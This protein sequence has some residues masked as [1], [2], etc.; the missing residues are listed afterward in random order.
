MSSLFRIIFLVLIVGCPFFS[1]GQQYTI[2]QVRHNADSIMRSLVGESIFKRCTY[3]PHTYYNYKGQRKKEAEWS[4]LDT[5]FSTRGKVQNIFVR[6]NVKYSYPHCPEYNTV[7]GVVSL[8]LDNKLQLNVARDLNIIPDYMLKGEECHFI[9][10]EEAI[11]TATKKGMRTLD[12]PQIT[13]H[14]VHFRKQF[15]WQLVYLQTD[16]TMPDSRMFGAW[17]TMS[18]DAEKG[19]FI[20]D[21]LGKPSK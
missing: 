10:K 2:E 17:H 1:M 19:I 12:K 8:D 9:T 18:V 20:S 15:L 11:D 16:S 3:D 14:Y 4:V 6:Y 7:T 13:L 21:I 5:D